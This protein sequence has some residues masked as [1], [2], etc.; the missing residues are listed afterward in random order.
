MET[1]HDPDKE[2]INREKHGIGFAGAS[3]IFEAY[4]IDVED[5]R[6]DYGETRYVTLGRIGGQIVVCVWTPRGVKARLISMRKADKDEREIYN[7]YRP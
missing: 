3:A 1:E 7:L 2:R 4:R 5:E 6:E